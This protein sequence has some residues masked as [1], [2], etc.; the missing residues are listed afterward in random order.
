MTGYLLVLLTLVACG[1]APEADPGLLIPL[2]RGVSIQALDSSQG[3]LPAQDY[4]AVALYEI[5]GPS[6]AASLAF[7][8]GEAPEGVDLASLSFYQAEGTG[9]WRSLPIEVG[10][11]GLM[12]DAQPGRIG[13]FSYQPEALRV[14]AGFQAGDNNAG[15]APGLLDGIIMTPATIDGDGALNL[16]KLGASPLAANQTWIS[17]HFAGSEARAAAWA[18]NRDSL[19]DNIL[20]TLREG[21]YAGFMLEP[22]PIDAGEVEALEGLLLALDETLGPDYGLALR[23]PAPALTDS[24]WSSQPYDWTQLA[25]PL[26]LLVIGVPLGP[27]DWHSGGAVA[28]LIDLARRQVPAHKLALAFSSRSIDEWAGSASPINLDYALQPL[29][30]IRSS[31]LSDGLDP[32]PGDSLEFV[33]SGDASNMQRDERSGV[34]RYDVFAGDGLHRVWIVTGAS[35]RSRLDWLAA[36]GIST[37]L[38]DDLYTPGNSPGVYTAIAEARAG[39]LS[40]L[41]PSLSLRWTIEDVSNGSILSSSDSALD[42]RLAWII[43]DEGEYVVR[44]ALSADTLTELSSDPVL[45]AGRNVAALA[46]QEALVLGGAPDLQTAPDEQFIAGDFDLGTLP[47]P[48]Y[49]AGLASRGSFELGGQVNHVVQHPEYMRQAGM[50][51]VKF[52]LTWH[53]DTDPAVAARMVEHAHGLGF[54]VLLSIVGVEKNPTAINI[55][56]YLEFVREAAR[57]NPDAIEVWNEPNLAFEWPIGQVHGGKYVQ[58]MLA[59]AYNVIKAV[60]PDIIVVSAAPAPNGAFFGEGGCSTQGLGCDDWLYVQQMAYAG[61]A[62]YMDCVG[63][64][65][66]AGATAPS[67]TSGHPADPGYQHYSW[68]Y[69]SMVDLYYGTFGRPICFTELGYLSSEGYPGV[70]ARFSWAAATNTTNQ[71]AWLAEAAAMAK[72]SGAV[73]LMIVWNVD[74]TYYG[75]DPMAGYA[76]VRPGGDC[77]ACLSLGRV[78]GR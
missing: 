49:T 35:L 50:N 72:I 71:A 40:S 29:G 28:G 76:I 60:D 16:D 32:Q 62:N 45:V 36:M 66:N 6:N 70:P 46:V 4:R 59:P 20:N 53:P 74:F 63:V 24:G 64:H 43:E 75:D 39:Q 55:A 67:V 11:D 25:A 21:D 7:R 48:I 77:P 17:A 9:G 68:Y 37:V 27:G 12:I 38:I 73:R 44:A 65:Y 54:K 15:S 10:E 42:G 56:D 13:V 52:Q 30:A 8:L 14:L 51:W 69:Q 5:G 1:A 78:M 41:N 2:T 61:A 34:Y 18:E 26:D 23:P 19:I 33:L 22:G 57:A 47:I 31:S 3:P 58:W